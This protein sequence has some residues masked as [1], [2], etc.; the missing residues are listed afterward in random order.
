MW[1]ICPTKRKDKSK[2]EQKKAEASK[3]KYLGAPSVTRGMGHTFE[4]NDNGRMAHTK[5]SRVREQETMRKKGGTHSYSCVPFVVFHC[6]II[7][8]LGSYL[9]FVCFLRS[10]ARAAYIWS[11]CALQIGLQAT[12]LRPVSRLVPN[13]CGYYL[14]SREGEKRG[15]KRGRRE[16][17]FS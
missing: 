12:Y 8:R 1:V 16:E 9:C 4:G 10:F 2:P 15:G 14:D 17:N 13:P 7:A 5:A 11:S 3:E 6:C